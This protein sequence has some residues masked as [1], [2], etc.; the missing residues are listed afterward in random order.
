[1]KLCVIDFGGNS[2]LSQ[3]VRDAFPDDT[4][5]TIFRNVLNSH[6]RDG[7]GEL[8][9]YTKAWRA[10]SEMGY[11]PGPDGCVWIQQPVEKSE[12]GVTDVHVDKP[13]AA[14][15]PNAPPA[16]TAP[17]GLGPSKGVPRCGNCV[18]FDPA[19]HCKQYNNYPVN[20]GM[21]CGTWEGVPS[22]KF[23]PPAEVQAAA[24]QSD[25]D[26]DGITEPLAKGEGLPVAEVR[27]IAEY[28]AGDQVAMAS[29]NTRNAWGGSHA[30]KWAARVLKKLETPPAP[31]VEK[32]DV[33]DF[34]I[35]GKIVKVDAVQH[36][37]FGW[38]SIVSIGDRLIFD[39][40]D[41]AI[42]PATIE[43][44]AYDFVLDSGVAGHMHEAG[45]G[46]KVTKI[47][48]LVESVVFTP[49]K[50]A[51]MLASLTDQGINAVMTMPFVGWWIGFKISNPETW[52]AVVSGRLKAFSIGGKG[53]R[54]AC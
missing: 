49:E 38:A 1:M 2:D 45:K 42:E 9:A 36:L 41:D 46:G 19:G 39:T 48:Q 21:V 26:V 14:V 10:M 29:I 43:A 33:V 4:L 6:L 13:I 28:F 32:A 16:S 12:P 53:K 52:E 50:T 31:V 11:V 35:E 44:S 25:R 18:H 20:A 34:E 3:G 30:A 15:D 22:T 8:L 47:G 54:A 24:K 5:Q 51:G 7:K 17:P 37:C 27:K 40:Q 23:V